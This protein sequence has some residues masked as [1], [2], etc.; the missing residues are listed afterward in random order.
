MSGSALLRKVLSRS[1][2][3]LHTAASPRPASDAAWSALMARA[4][5]GDTGSYRALLTGIASLIRCWGERQRIERPACEAM[6]TA[7]LIAVHRVRRTYDPKRAFLPWLLGVLREQAQ[8]QGCPTRVTLPD[9]SACA[10]R[11]GRARDA[12]PRDDVP[13]VP[14]VPRQSSG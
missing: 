1:G 11:S 4:Q 7:T 12:A 3:R 5:D 13:T 6:V 8:R 14:S 10:T 2:W 9:L